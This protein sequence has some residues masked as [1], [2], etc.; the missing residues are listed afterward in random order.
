[1]TWVIIWDIDSGDGECIERKTPPTHFKPMF[2]NELT[3]NQ[4]ESFSGGGRAERQARREE[5]REAR[6]RRR[7]ERHGGPY[8]G[9]TRC[10]DASGSSDDCDEDH[11]GCIDPCDHMPY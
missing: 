4:L 5:R 8:V 9:G 6:L 10:P 3:L 2:N 7:Q 11:R 1:M